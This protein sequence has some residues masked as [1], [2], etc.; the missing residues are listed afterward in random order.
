MDNCVK[1]TIG[2]FEDMPIVSVLTETDFREAAKD[3][4]TAKELIEI[5][6]KAY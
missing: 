6:K 2:M 1:V 5:E 4:I 3:G